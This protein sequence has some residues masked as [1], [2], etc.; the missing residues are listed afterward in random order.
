[1]V[2]FKE[3]GGGGG[4]VGCLVS[5]SEKRVV[6]CKR[7]ERRPAKSKTL[8][9]QGGETSNNDIVRLLSPGGAC[10]NDF[11]ERGKD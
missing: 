7:E 3:K 2:P 10:S 1:M 11:Q 6:V 5:R 8:W 9:C 4:G